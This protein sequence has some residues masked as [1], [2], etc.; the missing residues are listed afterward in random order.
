MALSFNAPVDIANRA[1]Q[2][3]GA[4]R[5]GTAGFNEDS[6][7]ASETAFVY[8]KLRRAELRRN[9][10]RFAI[11]EAVLRPVSPTTTQI[12]ALLWASSTTYD[13]G[14]IVTDATG[15]IWS[16]NIN[17]NLNNETGS[18][19]QWEPYYGAL[20]A[21]AFDATT[22]YSAGE[23][24]YVTTGN[25]AAQV[26]RSLINA[27]E[28]VPGT[29]N[30]Y[31]AAVTYLEGQVVSYLSVTY[32]SLIDFN[33]GNTPSAA[34]A[35]WNSGTTYAIGNQVGGSDGIIYTSL[36]NGNIGHDPTTDLL[37]NWSNA[38]VLNP[39]TTVITSGTGSFNWVPIDATLNPLPI[40]YPITAGVSTQNQTRNVFWLPANFLRRAP[41]DPKAGSISYLGVPGNLEADDWRFEAR[42]IVS[43]QVD[44]IVLRFVA[45]IVD[46]TAMDEMFCE[47]LAARIAM[48][49]CEP[50]TQSASKLQTIRTAYKDVMGDA[51]AVNGIEVGAQEPPLD[52]FIACR[53]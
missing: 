18:S 39:W 13:Y 12:G 40:L 48:E 21:D 14:A 33:T 31:D 20:V 8:D 10:W 11:R 16:S 6:K 34:P 38:G 25:G 23:M 51:R 50:I 53:F 37:S 22:S 36:T 24:V 52:D 7:N 43:A 45:D 1:L 29:I 44:P 26:Y 47:G 4:T 49:V 32:Q 35:L 17:N 27:N 46:V 42:Y 9:V 2:H 30:T 15:A 19:P 5:L 28:D 3:C 41:Q